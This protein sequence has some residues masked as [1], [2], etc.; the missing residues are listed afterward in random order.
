[1]IKMYIPSKIE[2]DEILEFFPPDSIKNFKKENLIT[3]LN[4]LSEIPANLERYEN[5]GEYIPIHSKKLQRVA[6]NYRQYFDY[7]IDVGIIES[8]NLYFPDEKSKGYRISPGYMSEV[9]AYGVEDY[10]LEK[11]LNQ[12]YKYRINTSKRYPHTRWYDPKLNIDLERSLDQLQKEKEI[13]ISNNVKHAYERYNNAYINI[14]RFNDGDYN[15]SI[16]GSVGRL[17]SRLTCMKKDYRKFVKYGDEQLVTVDISNSQPYLSTILFNPDFY[18]QYGI[19]NI[20]QFL[21]GIEHF[22]PSFVV[23][24]TGP[25]LLINSPML[26]KSSKTPMNSDSQ[27][28]L[29]LVKRGQLYEYMVSRLM[30]KTGDDTI[31]REEVKEQV[32]IAINANTV[33]MGKY[34]KHKKNFNKIFPTVWNFFS[35]F[36]TKDNSFLARLLHRV[37]TYLIHDIICKRLD[38][39]YPNIPIYTIHDCIAT[40]EGNENLIKQIMTEELTKY[41]GVKPNLKIEHG[42]YQS[43]IVKIQGNDSNELRSV[44]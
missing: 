26:V 30:E 7:L 24:P 5:W 17:H 6:H 12:K 37:E 42:Q 25:D 36:K 9:A 41:I 19:L 3:F 15:I 10:F 43:E 34:S 28:Y 35:D 32:L 31:T 8:D 4:M 13:N 23:N 22:A 2:L 38:N 14:D 27:L 11:K 44:A 18:S 20:Y 29:D 40:T 39:D 33:F 16:D 21:S 1:M